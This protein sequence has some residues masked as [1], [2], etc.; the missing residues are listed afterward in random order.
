YGGNTGNLIVHL[1]GT[2]QGDR[3]MF[4][5]HMDTVPGAVDTLAKVDGDWIVS[6]APGKALGGDNRAGCATVLQVARELLALNGQHPPVTLVFFIQ[7]EVGLVG[8]RGMNLDLLGSP[9]PSICF[10]FD[11]GAPNQLVTKV[12]GTER[13]NIHIEGVAAHAGSRP[14]KGVSA[15][16]I[17]SL[18]IAELEQNGWHGQIDRSEG[19]GSANIGTLTGGTGSNVVMPH[20]HILAEARSHSVAFRKTIIQMY[21]ETFERVVSTQ[22]SSEGLRGSVQFSPGPTYEPFDLGNDSPVIL[23]A[24]K[25]AQSC[26]FNATCVTNNGG[27]DANWIVAH[28]IPAVTIGVGQENAH[29]PEERLSL[30]RFHQACQLAVAIATQR[31]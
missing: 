22:Q 15:A 8:A 17:A 13:F 25:A 20:L 27:M 11:G 23:A 14:E 5:T 12:I 1:N 19:K 29:T 28:G 6:D 30:P 24:Q 7:E 9:R 10:N 18:A 31:E 21:K 26:G 4:S 3:W 2:G 16:V